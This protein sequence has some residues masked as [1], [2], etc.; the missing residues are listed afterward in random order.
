MTFKSRGAGLYGVGYQWQFNGVNIS[1]AT[2]GALTLTGVG[3]SQLGIYDVVV[4]DNAGMGSI[5]S[6]NVNL[7]LVTTPT[8]SAETLL[9][10]EFVL[11]QS[12]VTLNVSATAPGQTDGF[13]LSYQWQLNG[14]NISGATSSTYVFAATNS[15][16]YSVIVSNAAGSITNAWQIM[17][18]FPGGVFG[19]GLNS[20][21][22]LNASTILTNVISLGAGEAHGLVALD[23]G[24][25]SNWGS[26]W[27][28]T[29]FIPVTAPPIIT[30]ALA[31]AA[32]SRHDLALLQNGTV[33]AWGLNDFGQT[34]VPADATNATAIAAGGQQSLALLQNGTVLQWGQTNAPIPAGLT[35]VTAI[36]AG[37]NFCLALLSNATVVAWGANNFGQT[38]FPAGLSNVVAVAAGGAHALALQQNG[39]VV[40]WGDN[41]YG[42]TNVPAGLSNVMN[43]AAGD[44]HSIALENNGTVIAWGDNTFGETNS[45]IGLNDIKL[46]AGGGDFTLASQFSSLT[47]YPVNVSQDLLLVYNSNSS[48]SSN[49]CAYYLAHRPMVANANVLGVAS[50]VG[51]F[52]NTTNGTPNYN[53][54]PQV[55]TP[56]LNWLTNNPT[57][58]PTYVIL[59]YDVPI[60][61]WVYP[62]EYGCGLPI[63]DGSVSYQIYSFYP[64]WKPFVNNIN[65]GSLADCEAYVDKIANMATHCPGQL[66][67]SASACGYGN[68][69]YAVDNVRNSA[70]Y[71]IYGDGDFTDDGYTVSNALTGLTSA[72][73]SSN[74]VIYNDGLDT[75]TAA[76]TNGSTNLVYYYAPQITTA[77]NVAG[78]ICWGEHSALGGGYPIN[79]E[80]TWLGNSGWWV[81]ETVESFNGMRSGCGQG[82]FVQWFSS[83]AF[84]GTNYSNTPVGAV[85]HVEEPFLPGI[86]NSSVYFGLWAAE[87]NF[88]ICAWNS[89][90]TP[91]FQAVGDPFVTH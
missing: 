74:A 80:V 34:N 29:S 88:A 38:N 57:K 48:D 12:N 42:E 63:Y 28:G 33:V 32:G 67:I 82:N 59:F 22:Q 50:E 54:D 2:N 91:F 39:I 47:M 4:T 90:Q 13:P 40:A 19:W 71:N 8:I 6:S 65:A 56:V 31:V 53:W 30:N 66:V 49:L 10:N 20:N 24:S 81:I 17:V 25:V 52:Y 85:S 76:I 1:G 83:N 37:T 75:I 84:G 41:T 11:Y 21:G 69:N 45:V 78:Y 9:T 35:N 5:V 86:E 3:P 77:T 64:G 44:N 46:I 14:T 72:G 51:E 73:V 7:Y 16:T 27:T 70:G 58:H 18:V 87:K 36:A 15:G 60:R 61:L 89:R 26:Y 55:V 43:I 62:T 23:S 79:G 68:T